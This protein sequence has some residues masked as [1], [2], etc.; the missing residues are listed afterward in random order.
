MIPGQDDIAVRVRAL[1]REEFGAEI[2]GFERL[3]GGE[4]SRAFGFVANG[5]AYV[6]R[7]S[8]YPHAVEAFAKDDYAWRRF[9]SAALP[10]PRIV[11]LGEVA[12]GAFAIGERVAGRRAEELTQAERAALVPSLLATLGAIG[13]AEVGASRGYGPWDGAGDG[14]A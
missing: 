11:A 3:F 8:V 6:V 14:V 7:F 13:G 9:A 5:R 4:F 1:V 12:G 10:I 2:G